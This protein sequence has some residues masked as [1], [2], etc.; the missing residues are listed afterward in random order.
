MYRATD[1]CPDQCGGKLRVMHHRGEG[2]QGELLHYCPTGF[3]LCD[4]CGG[5][6]D[7]PDPPDCML[8][9]EYGPEGKW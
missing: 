3:L 9:D 2:E 4:I 8:W 7:E 6:A 5:G 1:D